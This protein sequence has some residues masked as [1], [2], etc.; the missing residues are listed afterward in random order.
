MSLVSQP[1]LRI[2][3]LRH[4]GRRIGTLRILPYRSAPVPAVHCPCPITHVQPQ[5]RDVEEASGQR[6]YDRSCV[7]LLREYDAV[8]RGLGSPASVH[9][10]PFTHLHCKFTHIRTVCGTLVMPQFC[11]RPQPKHPIVSLEQSDY[12]AF[13]DGAPYQK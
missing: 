1:P 7:S 6:N 13:T 3:V 2:N 4:A 10:P 11:C 5:H 12:L 9:P 8:R